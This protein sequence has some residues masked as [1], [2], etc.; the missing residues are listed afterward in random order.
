M[1]IVLLDGEK[2]TGM[3]DVHRAFAEALSFP[4]ETGKNLD[5]LFDM[6]TATKEEI[7]VVLVNTEEL[8]KAIGRRQNSFFRMLE[9]VK[10]E[11]KGFSYKSPFDEE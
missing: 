2:I 8:K 9:D 6:L 7:G 3:K 5:A 11:R 1:K 10:K 4:P